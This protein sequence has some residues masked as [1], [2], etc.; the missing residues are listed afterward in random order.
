MQKQIKEELTMANEGTFWVDEE[1]GF[2]VIKDD[3]G[4]EDKYVIEEQLDIDDMTYLILVPEDVVEN[5]DA[6]AFVLKI[7][8]D[9]EQE[10][11]SV[12]EDESEFEKVKESYLAID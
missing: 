10:V 3:S 1:A 6:E 8:G 9:G 12:V 5:E 7:V 2:L 4:N 11:L